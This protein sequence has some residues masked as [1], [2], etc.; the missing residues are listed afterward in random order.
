VKRVKI[1]PVP[2]TRLAENKDDA[3]HI[4]E[5]YILPALKNA[6]AVELDFHG[7]E[8]AT[9]SF[10]HALISE[11]VR[12]YGEESFDRIKFTHCTE[13]VKEIVLTVFEYTFAAADAAEVYAKGSPELGFHGSAV[14]RLVG[15]TYRQLDYWARTDLVVPSVRAA[16]ELGAQRLYSFADVVELRIIKR[17]LDIG[18]SLRQI[19]DA[20]NYLKKQSG[21]RLNRSDITLMSDGKHIYACHTDAEILEVLFRGRAVFA[22]AVG[23]VWDDTEDDIAHFPTTGRQEGVHVTEDEIAP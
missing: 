4:R 23:L 22:I 20:T 14:I 5:N 10:V 13:E 19:R 2:G 7:I 16:G 1:R 18:V 9:Q 6:D 11:A 3:R 17:L 21:G 15:I 8:F 12:R